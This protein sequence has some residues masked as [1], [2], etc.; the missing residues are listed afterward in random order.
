MKIGIDMK[1]NYLLLA[2]ATVALFSCTRSEVEDPDAGGVLVTIHA[3]QEGADTR[4]TL[5]D[6][7]TQVYWEPSD[8]IK[9][10]FRGSGSRFLSQNTANA[11]VT[12]FSGSLNVVVGINEG[13]S[14]SNTLWGLY[15]YRADATSDGASVTTTLPAEQTGRAGSFAKNTNITLAQ[16]NSFDL[17]F[18]NVTG[19][20]RFSLTQEGVKEV[21]FEGQNNEN[22]AGKVK[23]AFADS[24]PAVQEILEGQ[25]TITLSAP[26][27]GTFETG[28]WYYIVALPG[29]LSNGF[30]MTFNTDTQY[31][32]LKSSGA[33]TIKRGIF[34]SL[35]D[36]DEGLIYK[37]KE[38]G[39]TPN[40]DD[41]IQFEDPV[42][43]YACVDKFDA[44]GDGEISYAE[45]AAVTSLQGLFKD[46]NTVTSFE[47]IRYFTSVTSTQNVFTGL[48]KLTK[49]TIPDII[50][51]L[52]TFQG[53]VALETVSLPATLN[54]LPTYCFDGCSSLKS[55]TLPVEISSIPDYAFRNC[56][57]LET[58]SVPSTIKSVGQYA[59]SGCTVLTDID[60]PSGFQT[61]GNYAFQNCRAIA[62]VDFP[63]SLTSL[64]SY[65]C[66][67][68]TALSS[69]MIGNSVSVG[70]N[71]F[72]GCTSLA[73]ATIGSGSSVGYS[74]FSGCTA[75]V[76]AVLASGVS[77]V[78]SNA[79]SGCSS[80]ANVVLPED[81]TSIPNGC[82]QNCYS[83]SSITWPQVLTKICDYAFSGCTFKNADYTFELPET[84][85]SIGSRAFDAL[86]HI[87]VPSNTLVSIASDSFN[88]GFIYIY[89]PTGL[90]DSYK[91]RTNWSNYCVYIRPISDYPAEFT[92][93]DIV[94]LGLSV[95]WSA[96]N[97]GASKFEDYGDYFAWGETE[98]KDIYNW[99]HYKF[100]TSGDRYDLVKF[101]KYNT[102]SYHGPIDNKI[103]LDPED[104]AATK[105]WG[106]TW[107]LP[108]KTEVLELITSCK[109][110]W[111]QYKGISG[112]RVI[113]DKE[114]YNDKW[115][116]LPAAGS[117]SGSELLENKSHYWSSSLDT[118]QS[119]YAISIELTSGSVP[120]NYSFDFRSHGLPVRPVCN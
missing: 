97:I 111:T 44:D 72:S 110:T 49:I 29:T 33:K 117:R 116:F 53:C 65:A 61:I 30:K 47:E 28:K 3:S 73:T 56:S 88:L 37:D 105:N 27:G 83:L 19:G 55:V 4:T 64:G 36:A 45:A 100:R 15:P 120:N 118:S 51:T 109:W 25:K 77:V 119:F 52:G 22:I 20:I 78:G 82:F 76:S 75:L 86:H 79:F 69:V 106:E 41:V 1:Y 35:A 115:I 102:S 104:D 12:D 108:T 38:G 63:A 40:P 50:T 7:G 107:R 42:A 54:A 74:A 43:K 21:I 71:A 34:G 99:A 18:Y 24:V 93:G 67:G 2:L 81:M 10:F 11:Q 8:E 85:Q 91:V 90:V 13:A 94:D 59:F 96:Y 70:S 68:C 26:N 39:D 9:V 80:L 84:I 58:I 31:A 87:I 66:S 14:G 46:W 101:S 114:G 16:S 92:C 48:T 6:G 89:V 17:A 112:Y 60:L 113:S 5:V 62:S 32:T 95:K 57:V 98:P 23:L 103:T